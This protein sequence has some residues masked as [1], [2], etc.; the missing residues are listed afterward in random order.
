[1]LNRLQISLLSALWISTF[2]NWATLQSFLNAP[3]AG[4]GIHAL[5][6]LFGGWLFIFVIN[7]ALILLLGVFFWG[8]TIKIVCI[9]LLI[10]SA[11]LGYF[12]LFL[13]TQFDKEMFIN[14]IQSD[15]K[16][17]FE[18]LNIRFL[19]WLV[20]VGFM[21]AWFVW[22]APLR[23]ELSFSRAVLAPTVVFIGLLTV[24][25]AL[26]YVM[27][28]SY[29]SAGRNHAISFS[30][31]A[32]ANIIHAGLKYAYDLRKTSTMRAP[33]GEDAH[34]RYMIEK[35]RLLVLVLGETARAMSQGLNGYVRDTTPQMRA[36]NGYY[37]PDTKSC[38]TS[39]AIS[40]PCLFSGFRRDD[41]GL[42]K[43]YSTET[44]IDV[45]VHSDVRVLWRDNDSGC[46]GV[47]AK[48][49]Y[50]NFN[51]SDNM[52]WCLEPGNCYDEVLLEGLEERLREERKETFVVLHIKGSHGP[53]YYKRYPKKFEK[54]LPVCQ[55]NDLSACN[56]DEIRNAYDNTILYSDH[57]VG[58]TIK[59]LQ[60]LSDQFATGLLYLSDHGESIGELGLFLHGM[61]YVIAP[62]EQT[63]VPMYFWV[64]PQFLQMERWDSSCM[65][66]QTKRP[67]SHDNFYSTI[68]GFMEI[69]T[70]EYNRSLDLFEPCDPEIATNIKPVR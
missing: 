12:S 6:F 17:A 4:D 3:S 44:L 55:S 50:E 66:Q 54:F 46:K 59:L 48:A 51:S 1:M 19:L 45:L 15:S 41:F 39:T 5:L 67:R 47:C 37:F 56:P 2:S 14:I 33:R 38:G 30:T 52:R 7:L 20:V 61:P 35:P 63:L 34:Q 65:I 23:S 25:A 62:K 13:G 11:G 24:N 57:I 32:P 9:A 53:A 22:R 60:K 28:P 18:L 29:A 42:T 64:S 43:A 70:Q 21:P 68:L 8:K 27:Y 40:I 16:E 36:A 31:L 58:Q 26:I 49:S 10:L 69:D